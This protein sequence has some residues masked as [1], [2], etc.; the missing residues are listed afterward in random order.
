MSLSESQ[1]LNLGQAAD[2]ATA[3]E[4]NSVPAELTVSQWVLESGWGTR[5]PGWNPF[6]IKQYPGCSERLLLAT[7]EWFTLAQLAAFLALGDSR[8]ATPTGR[9]FGDRKEYEVQD[10]FA[11]FPSLKD[12]FT[13]H[14]LLITTGE[15]YA[16]AWGQ[17]RKDGDVS[18][19]VSG[20]AQHY[21]TAPGYAG[22]L[23][24]IIRMADVRTAI[25][26]AR[27]LETNRCN[28]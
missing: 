23:L 18:A 15:P 27:W 3:C 1:V 24:A 21:A 4:K 12:A 13:R 8:T 26:A 22:L 28:H 16:A 25:D 10:W 11:S 19:L 5:Q 20:V 7:K 9:V 6:G 17:Y 2:A 14:N